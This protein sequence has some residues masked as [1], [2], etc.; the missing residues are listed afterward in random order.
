MTSRTYLNADG[1]YTAQIYAVPIHY[2]APN[3]SWEPIA[4]SL[5]N[6]PKA[7]FATA[8]TA[9]VLKTYLPAQ[10]SGWVRVEDGNASISFRPLNTTATSALSASGS[11]ARGSAWANTTLSYTV[12][13]GAL[14]ETLTLSAPGAPASFSFALSLDGLAATL[15]KDNSVTLSGGPDDLV[16]PAPWMKDA[17]GNTG[18]AIA[19]NLTRQGTT[20][21]Y[22]LTPDPAWLATATYPVVIDPSV[23]VPVATAPCYASYDNPTYTAFTTGTMKVSVTGPDQ[24]G[25]FRTLIRF[26]PSLPADA[27]ITSA[28]VNVHIT[29]GSGGTVSWETRELPILVH[30]P[31]NAPWSNDIYRTDLVVG[32]DLT[33]YASG[34]PRTDYGGSGNY[35]GVDAT[36]VVHSWADKR[37]IRDANGVMQSLPLNIVLHDTTDYI[38]TPNPS[39]GVLFLDTSYFS[40]YVNYSTPGWYTLQGNPRHTGRTQTAISAT[41]TRQWTSGL[42]QQHTYSTPDITPGLLA[43]PNPGNPTSP[44]PIVYA[45]TSDGQ[46]YSTV[47]RLVDNGTSVSIASRRIVFGVIHGTPLLYKGVLWVTGTDSLAGFMYALNADDLTQLAWTNSPAHPNPMR[48]NRQ[49]SGNTF[50]GIVYSSPTPNPANSGVI[51]AANV[52]APDGLGQNGSGFDLYLFSKSSTTGLDQWISPQL[53]DY[54]VYDNEPG[55]YVVP[56]IASSPASNSRQAYVATTHAWVNSVDLATGNNPNLSW[57][58]LL[59]GDDMDSRGSVTLYNGRVYGTF[60]DD[61][62]V[63]YPSPGGAASLLEYPDHA[64]ADLFWS[65]ELYTTGDAYS[66]HWVMTTPALRAEPNAVSNS[67]SIIF[68]DDAGTVFGVGTEQ[69]VSSTLPEVT[70]GSPYQTPSGMFIRSSPLVAGV[71]GGTGYAYIVSEDGYI[72][73]LDA[74]T[75]QYVSR[76]GPR[77]NALVHSNMAAF[78]GRLYAISMSG[79]IACFQ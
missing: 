27:E 49:E 65:G 33:A 32:R 68:G 72:Y 26:N 37:V 9:N 55:D 19:A 62:R 22:T 57:A 30:P 67:A 16:I 42:G 13:P 46:D 10:S 59:S 36:D 39:G 64:G 12:Q 34:I 4:T 5:T 15:N 51:V 74:D 71:P 41:S 77:F 75:G 20:F 8:N 50:A 40:L 44:Y 17:A 56:N 60:Q 35:T 18:T 54:D 58:Q 61:D 7:G 2:K 48:F 69:Q 23:T 29:G 43:V 31:T 53:T 3:G 63:G 52:Q 45:V 70:W 6:S 47:Y 21:V 78:K 25:A 14:K 28:E 11:E 38:G 66:D 76:V 1:T 73:V 24:T 79:N